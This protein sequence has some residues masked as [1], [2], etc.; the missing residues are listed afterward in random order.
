MSGEAQR[1]LSRPVGLAL[2]PGPVALRLPDQGDHRVLLLEAVVRVAP[3]P[4]GPLLLVVPGEVPRV[5]Q[6][7]VLGDLPLEG[8]GGGGGAGLW[9]GGALGHVLAKLGDGEAVV[10]HAVVRGPKAIQRL[11]LAILIILPLVILP[12]VAA[13]LVHVRPEELAHML[14]RG[15]IEV[16]WGLDH[17]QQHSLQLLLEEDATLVAAVLLEG[18]DEVVFALQDLPLQ[19]RGHRPAPL[20]CP[21]AR[22]R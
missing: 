1:G 14:L 9:G 4:R 2:V 7:A 20:C 6:L 5:A 17:G 15:G 3:G 22:R 8:R 16:G 21:A 18:G 11:R 12:V 13:E 19:H 10:H